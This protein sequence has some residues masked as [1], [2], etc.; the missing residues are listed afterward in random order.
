MKR[1]ESTGV[2]RNDQWRAEHFSGG[3][4]EVFASRL[5]GTNSARKNLL[6]VRIREKLRV[7]INESRVENNFIGFVHCF[8]KNLSRGMKRREAKQNRAQ[9]RQAGPLTND[10]QSPPHD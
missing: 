6:N 2:V 7:K 3:Q 5:M 1:R 10:S 8:E 4:S 9:R